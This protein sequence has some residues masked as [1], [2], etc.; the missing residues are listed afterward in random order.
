MYSKLVSGLP[1]YEKGVRRENL[2]GDVVGVRPK[3]RFTILYGGCQEVGPYYGSYRLRYDVKLVCQRKVFENLEGVPNLVSGVMA[4]K[5]VRWKMRVFLGRQ[6][7][8][9]N[10]VYK[11]RGGLK[12]I[13]IGYL[14]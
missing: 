12:L 1:G 8:I 4:Q 5:T 2:V 9:F 7:Q 14:K 11:D 3:T 10:R 13:D 6:K